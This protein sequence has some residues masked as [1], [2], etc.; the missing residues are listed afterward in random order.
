MNVQTTPH[1]SPVIINMSLWASLTG[2]QQKAPSSS[3]NQSSS[4]DP[5][6]S[7]LH[8]TAPGTTFE[9]SN[10]ESQ[11][12]SILSSISIPD[13][14]ELHPLAGLNTG[15]LDYLT[16]DD[17]V[18]SDLPGAQSALPSRG[19]SDDLCY[20]TGVTY[21]TALSIGGAWGLVEG[22]N[23]SPASAAP[24]L[25]LNSVL[26]S[27][28]RRGPFLGNSV[29]VIAL[30]YNIVNSSLD[31]LRGKH[32]SAN[33]IMSGALSGMLF[34]STRGVRPMLISGGLVAGAA[35]VWTVSSSL[36]YASHD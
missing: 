20:G 27:V 10:F 6:A 11:N 32:D 24:R 33:S 5:S 28:T 25:R 3:S 16:L 1:Q 13:V 18:L 12:S 35:S 36:L 22:L 30:V 34:K 15:S 8:D 26:N 14:A 4:S 19:W 2:K 23:R 21:V 7:T 31:Q 17:S 29:A 9:P